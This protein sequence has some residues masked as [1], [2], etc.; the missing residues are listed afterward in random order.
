[1]VAA[2]DAGRVLMSP[3]ALSVVRCTVAAGVWTAFRLRAVDARG[4]VAAL[5]AVGGLTFQ[6][7]HGFEHAV[8]FARWLGSPA[9]PPWMSSWALAGRD[10]LAAAFGP[11]PMVG[12]ELLHLIGNAI[13]LAGLLALRRVPPAAERAVAVG[14]RPADGP[15]HVSRS[16][17]IKQ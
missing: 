13:F 16:A 10:G 9:S 8:Q 6:A 11:S 15:C 5:V 1:M 4:T 12:M 17:P 3:L 7:V 2:G 14:A